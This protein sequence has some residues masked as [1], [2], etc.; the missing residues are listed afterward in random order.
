MI[1]W[2]QNALEKKGRVIFIILLAVVIVSFV[3][4]IG[5]TPGCVSSEPGA[6]VQKYYG[7]SLN[8]D[9]DPRSRELVQEVVISSIVNRGQQPQNEQV[10]TQEFLSRA[11]L[12]H[13]ADQ[14]KIPEPNQQ[15]FVQYLS[16]IA[17]FQD[18]NGNFDPN[19]VTNFLDM[20]QLSRQFDEATINRALSN[21][22]RIGQLMSSIV[23]PGFTIPF[24]VEEQARRVRTSYD[25]SIA[26]L[27][28]S[29]VDLTVE[30][31]DEDL[32]TFFTQQVEAYRVPEKRML[33][34]VTF[35]PDN[36][37][38]EIGE[39]SEEEL[40]EY[41]SSNRTNYLDA[42]AE[43]PADALPTFEKVSDEVL[44]D[45][46]TEQAS[47]LARQKSEEYV[48]TL[49][50][51]EIPADSPQFSEVNQQFGLELEALPPMVGNTPPAGTDIP[52]IAFREAVLLDELRYFSDPVETD[53]GITVLILNEV[54]P[55]AI[56]QLADVREEV[57]ADYT[58]K[59]EQELLVAR[60]EEIRV[61]LEELLKEGN[62]FAEAAGSLGLEV[63]QFD[64]VSWENIPTGFD[65]S[66]IRR[67]ESLPNG[68]VSA[69]VVTSDGGQFLYVEDR[70]APAFKPDSEEYQQSKSML[71]SSTSRLFMSS[72]VGDLIQLGM[73]ES[74]GR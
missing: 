12:L 55:S 48:Y 6:Q 41:F 39:P 53:N 34:V 16:G 42:E 45:W 50:N 73:G 15:A 21:D 70:G 44:S 61:E 3:F 30:P 64:A 4:V 8:A 24:E 17:F 29:A 74:E 60:G 38:A 22:Y 11:A 46:K 47:V 66:S 72:F 36:F 71:A 7:Y 9:V 40:Q 33:S 51:K 18:E 2:I 25:L 27:G 62:T 54:I 19:R 28:T 58:E 56:P 52:A 57:V 35:T 65:G 49:F 69:M 32:E 63:E 23:A 20:T 67:A 10:L 43:N 1:S 13:L 59:K 5:E 14:T 37:V 26:Q 68:E 31:S